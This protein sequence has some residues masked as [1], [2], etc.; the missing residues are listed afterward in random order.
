MCRTDLAALQPVCSDEGQ[1]VYEQIL[2]CS[3][4]G[5]LLPDRFDGG[6]SKGFNK[7]TGTNSVD[8]GGAV[9]AATKYLSKVDCKLQMASICDCCAMDCKFMAFSIRAERAIK[10]STACCVSMEVA[11]E[12]H[13]PYLLTLRQPDAVSLHN[14]PAVTP[15]RATA[16]SNGKQA[17]GHCQPNGLKNTNRNAL[18]S[19]NTVITQ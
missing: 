1:P 19:N 4:D 18:F 13:S 11:I 2:C 15:C 16:A 7:G 12:A 17:E 5:S 9:E 3:K 6:D 14:R 10:S 8:S